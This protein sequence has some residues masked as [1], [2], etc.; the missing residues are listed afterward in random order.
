MGEETVTQE[1]SYDVLKKYG[2]KWAVL[3][4]MKIDLLNHGVTVPDYLGKEL[5]S[6][7]IKISSGCFS[8]CEVGCL[9]GKLEGAFIGFGA[10][11]GDQFIEHWSDLLEKAFTGEIDYQDISSIPSLVPVYSECMFLECA[12]SY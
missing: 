9:L 8:T 1:I 11:V 10:T 7:H 5:E 4:A 2:T 6:G 3:A 12:C